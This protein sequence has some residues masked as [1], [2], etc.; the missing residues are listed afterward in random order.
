MTRILLS[1][2]LII[3][4]LIHLAGFA[5]A[6]VNAASAGL[7]GKTWV[8]MTAT[9][10]KVA[11]YFWLCSAVLFVM[12]GA[13]YFMR[14]D[15]YWIVGAV[16]LVISQPLIIMYWQ[17]AKFGTVPNVLILLVIAISAAK[18]QFDRSFRLDIQNIIG[19]QSIEART[20][21]EEDI[22]HLPPT[23]QRWLHQS[24]VVGVPFGNV[25]HIFQRGAMRLKP[26]AKW[27]SFESE[28]YFTV[29]PP[30]FVW[31]AKINVSPLIT[32]AGKDKYENGEGNMVIKP[33]YI[34][35]LANSS[36]KEVNQGTLLRYLAEMAW[37][38]H[39]ATSDY[40]RW[41]QIDPKHARVT[42]HFADVTASG[43]YS[44]NDDGSVSGF[45][46][47]RYGDFNGVYRMETWSVNVT[48]YHT[49][50]GTIIGNQSEVAWKLKEG[51]FTWLK[52]E[53]VDVKFQTS[54]SG[55]E[56]EQ[57]MN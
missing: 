4:G 50:N 37:F 21:T 3:H 31:K 20:I 52:M 9:Q 35:P 36:G 7:P 16:A 32:I 44:F 56:K 14:K 38:P 42:M 30:A 34:F 8:S 22:R 48:G 5:K 51:D 18:F 13:F 19:K 12:S 23:V 28:Q 27:M 39:A 6:F 41:E 53:V 25:L 57:H 24:K 43:V 26:D 10:T 15:W 55:T 17:D 46:A 49:F 2:A 1:L 29:D 45:E 54:E 11:A 47:K 40:L 33:L